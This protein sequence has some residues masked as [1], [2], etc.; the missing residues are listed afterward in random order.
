[1]ICLDPVVEVG[2]RRCRPLAPAGGDCHVS[3]CHFADELHLKSEPE[4]LGD[5]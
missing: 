4:L 1:M 3:A 5:A 2:E